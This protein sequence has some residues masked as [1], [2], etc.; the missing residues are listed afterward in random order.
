M[1]LEVQILRIRGILD[2]FDTKLS[3]VLMQFLLRKCKDLIT[4]SHKEKNNNFVN[5]E[6]VST[7]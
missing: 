2:K 5:K 6:F 3:L 1:L 7:F 4:I